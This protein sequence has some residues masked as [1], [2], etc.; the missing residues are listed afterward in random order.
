MS[1]RSPYATAWTLGRRASWALALAFG[2][3]LLLSIG[4]AYAQ[5]D[6]T[7]PTVES[8]TVD[9]AVLTLTFSEALRETDTSGLKWALWVD[10]IVESS[11]LSPARVSI[12]GKTLTIIPG[13]GGIPRPDGYGELRCR[14]GWGKA[15]GRRGQRGGQLHRPQG[16]AR[17][18]GDGGYDTGTDG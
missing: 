10:G 18:V 15:P 16:A 14:L 1:R 12:S 8:A 7:P 11:P 5:T 3:A 2:L 9:G 6:E 17:R 4:L 13:H